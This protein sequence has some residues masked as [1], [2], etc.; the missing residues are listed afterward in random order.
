MEV[1]TKNLKVLN[2]PI[3]S[4][5]LAIIR[6]KNTDCEK[7]KNALKRITY[8]LLYES[9]LDLPMVKKT[10][11]TPLMETTCEVFDE[12]A[13]FII[14]PILRAGMIFCEIAQELLPFANVHHIGMY[15]DEETLEPVWYYDKRKEIKEDK[16]KV[17]VL[18]LDPMLATGNS[19]IDT[20]K[21]FISKGVKEENIIFMSLIS[22]PEGVKK[23][24]EKYRDVKIITAS[25][26][27]RLNS[28]GYIMPGLGDA[29]DRIYN[30]LD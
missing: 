30:T 23:V 27:E 29:G 3:I 15:R 6:D 26:D 25:L 8:A 2:H 1:L 21:N 5:N 7:F 10:V 22:S 11:E 14:A 20:I 24:S 19:A 18:I 17:F 28:K 12:N 13:Q 16:N 4:H 9:T